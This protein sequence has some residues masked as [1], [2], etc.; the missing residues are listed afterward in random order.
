MNNNISITLSNSSRNDDPWLVAEIVDTISDE[1]DLDDA[2]DFIDSLYDTSICDQSYE[3]SVCGAKFDVNLPKE[4]TDPTEEEITDAVV[5]KLDIQACLDAYDFFIA[6]LKI[7][8]SDMSVPYKLVLEGGENLSDVIVSDRVS[9]DIEVEGQSEVKLK[10]PPTTEDT[11]ALWSGGVVVNHEGTGVPSITVDGDYLVWDDSCTGV[12]SVTQDVTYNLVTVKVPRSA[13]TNASN[14]FDDDKNTGSCVVLI[15]WNKTV[16]DLLIQEAELQSTI[17][18]LESLCPTTSYNTGSS[19]DHNSGGATCYNLETYIKKCDCTGD[20]LSTDH[21]EHDTECTSSRSSTGHHLK[22]TYQTIEYVD[23]GEVEKLHDPEYY[24][25]KCCEPPTI[26]LPN[27]KRRKVTNRGGKEMSDEDKAYYTEKFDQVNFIAVSPE[28]GFCGETTHIQDVPFNNCCDYVDSIV[29]DKEDS[30]AVL[31]DNSSG[32][33][34]VYGGQLPLNVRVYGTGFY[35][36][37]SEGGTLDYDFETRDI[38]VL[39]TDACGTATYVISDDCGHVA[40]HR[41]RAAAG[42][43]V[44]IE[45]DSSVAF[46][47]QGLEADSYDHWYGNSP[48]GCSDWHYTGKLQAIATKDGYKLN[49]KHLYWDYGMGNITQ[50]EANL[51]EMGSN[52]HYYVI[53]GNTLSQEENYP[54]CS[55][56]YGVACASTVDVYRINVCVAM[57]SYTFNRDCIRE[58]ALDINPTIMLHK[59]RFGDEELFRYMGEVRHSPYLVST[60]NQSGNCEEC[61]ASGGMAT[62]GTSFYFSCFD[63]SANEL[64]EWQC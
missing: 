17:E 45:Y 24:E 2:A 9:Y 21:I 37:D 51:P 53:T 63:R 39:T 10:Y 31:A 20:T 44:E 27:C 54:G 33:I 64:W 28:D 48:G 1:A 59:L 8:R 35:V 26:A 22:K 11:I 29:V 7:Y 52:P 62:Y 15:F 5:D 40:T 13:S 18:Y 55:T 56:P 61:H 30:V 43:W 36:D 41:V 38:P 32:F 34:Y 58:T 57:N 60:G 12:I 4:D 50:G 6:E 14:G 47:F 3:T 23:C 16:T 19:S 42:Q 49:E 25:L 46:S